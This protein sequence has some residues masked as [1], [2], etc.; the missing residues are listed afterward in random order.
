MSLLG[1]TLYLVGLDRMKRELL[2]IVN[3]KDVLFKQVSNYSIE[4]F[5]VLEGVILSY[6]Y[7][8]VRLWKLNP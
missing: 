3:G 8:N 2:M 5:I 6:G 7:E 1:E 4:G